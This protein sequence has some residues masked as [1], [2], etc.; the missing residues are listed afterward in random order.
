[1]LGSMDAERQILHVGSSTKLTREQK[2]GFGFVIVCGIFALVLGG[3][4]IWTHMAAPFV[5]TYTGAR[6]QTGTEAEA[7]KIAAERK[8]D[9]DAD[10]VNDYDELYIYKTSPYL[11]DSDSDGLSDGSEIASNQDPNCAIGAACASVSNEDIQLST[12]SAALDAEG[13]ELATRQQA[14]EQTLAEL[15]AK[16]V[17]EIRVLLLASGADA[18]MLEAMSDDEVMVLYQQVLAQI[19]ASGALD[20]LVAPTSPTS[21]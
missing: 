3:Q 9:T 4:Y 5:I 14:L 2:A 12:G 8:Q 15:N 13:A 11:A 6:F 18:A 1:M 17:A 19:E 7:A 21:P 20:T 16:P 10:T